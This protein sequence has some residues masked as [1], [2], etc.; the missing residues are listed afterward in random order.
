MSLPFIYTRTRNHDYRLVTSKSL[1]DVSSQFKNLATE[2]ARTMID[3]SDKQLD[4]PSWVLIKKDG[5]V[6]W[7]ISVI[8]KALSDMS[9]DK[10]ERPV[11]GFFGFISDDHIDK[12]PYDISYFVEL[13]RTYVLPI[14]DSYDQLEQIIRPIP[15]LKGNDFI[16]KASQLSDEINI[17]ETTCRIFPYRPEIR[18]LI[19]AVFSSTHDCSIAIN[20]HKTE[21]C[22]K[23]G[24]D[25]MS[26]MN[27]VMSDDSVIKTI[28]DLVVFVQPMEEK[29]SSD[30][31]V[32]P[33]AESSNH[34]IAPLPTAFPVHN[35]PICIGNQLNRNH[36]SKSKVKKY[37]KYGLY[38]F[39]VLIC[40]AVFV[41]ESGLLEKFLL[42]FPAIEKTVTNKGSGKSAILHE[43][44][45]FLNT[46][47]PDFFIHDETKEDVFRINYESSS[48]I[49]LVEASNNWIRII[50]SCKDLAKSG[51]IEFACEFL[52]S[53]REMALSHY[54]IK[55]VK[56]VI[57][58][59]QKTYDDPKNESIKEKDSDKKI[60]KM[61][62]SEKTSESSSSNSREPQN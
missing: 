12:L 15:P 25:K 29:S 40:L 38:G 6:L 26:F 60:H 23:F 3:A 43:V 18:V 17:N 45:P 52:P 5:Y 10:C 16:E 21:Q 27:A 51:I 28:K 14:W 55:K 22:V 46:S 11:R 58:V 34:T 49:D 41:K 47:I 36:R 1:E 32:P 35:A 39:L 30:N 44:T 61:I 33:S 8:N 62:K 54:S 2:V 20:I 48:S 57:L 9:H 31:S 7:G 37:I 59:H 13:Y 24:D 56:K 53:V 42:H 50:S 19:E 4:K